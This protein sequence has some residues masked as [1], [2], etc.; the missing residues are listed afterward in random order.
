MVRGEKV[1]VFNM[2][3]SFPFEPLN[4]EHILRP[5]M[6]KFIGKFAYISGTHYLFWIEDLGGK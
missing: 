4:V 6:I 1:L 3:V 2:M 5:W